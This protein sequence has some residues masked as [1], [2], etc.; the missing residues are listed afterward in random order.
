[1]S[2]IC[3]HSESIPAASGKYLIPHVA[4]HLSLHTR[5]LPYTHLRIICRSMC[6]SA[7][8][9]LVQRTFLA[10]PTELSQFLNICR[11]SCV[12][13]FIHFYTAQHLASSYSVR[14]CRSSHPLKTQGSSEFGPTRNVSL[15]CLAFLP[16]GDAS[17]K[18]TYRIKSD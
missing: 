15:K 2:A 4:D 6:R 10:K 14:I 3:F 8:A 18:P 12:I 13:F 5:T 16:L 7:S 1:M 17:S 11:F 9:H